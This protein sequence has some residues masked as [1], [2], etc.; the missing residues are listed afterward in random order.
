MKTI[1]YNPYYGQYDPNKKDYINQ[2]LDRQNQIFLDTEK[3][4]DDKTIP[5]RTIILGVG[6]L[7]LVGVLV[8]YKYK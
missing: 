6:V 1:D 2:I 7:V 8:I 4:E 3:R 5:K